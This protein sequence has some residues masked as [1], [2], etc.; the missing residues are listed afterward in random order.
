MR[1]AMVNLALIWI[2][3][4]IGL[5]DAF[6][7]DFAVA[8][9]VACE[10]AVCTL[11]TGS[12][13][14]KFSTQSATHDVVKLLLDKLVSIL[15]VNFFLAGTNGTLSTDTSGERLLVATLLV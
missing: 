6:G 5:G 14:E 4:G 7:D 12:I 13:L 15:L 9:L 11:H 10:L 1:Y 8:I 3:L 2:R